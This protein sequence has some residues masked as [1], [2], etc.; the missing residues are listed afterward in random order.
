MF[1]KANLDRLKW[2]LGAGAL[3]VLSACGGGSE[4]GGATASGETAESCLNAAALATGRTVETKLDTSLV[5]KTDGVV[6]DTT[7]GTQSIVETVV[8]PALFQGNSAIKV[9]YDETDVDAGIV[10]NSSYDQYEN[11]IGSDLVT[12]GSENLNST[13]GTVSTLVSSPYALEAR[14]SLAP[15]QSYTHRHDDVLSFVGGVAQPAE[16]IS[17]TIKFDG[18]VSLNVQAG[19]FAKVCKFTTTQTSSTGFAVV[20]EY[21]ITSGSMLPIKFVATATQTTGA[22]VTAALITA[23]AT[24]VKVNGTAV[25]Q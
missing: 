16:A 25:T 19:N 4:G 15:G 18:Y 24:S 11:I 3:A 13:G 20:S 8:G 2:S 6:T 23:T 7:A 1:F 5:L 17:S 22:V 10:S 9:H 14:F 21:W 12:Y